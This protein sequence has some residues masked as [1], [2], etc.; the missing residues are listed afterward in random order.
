MILKYQLQPSAAL[1]EKNLQFSQE[2]IENQH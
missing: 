2:L 1:Q